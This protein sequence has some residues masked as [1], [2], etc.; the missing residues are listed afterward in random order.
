MLGKDQTLIITCFLLSA[1]ITYKHQQAG[2][3]F[4]QSTKMCTQLF[5]SEVVNVF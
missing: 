3:K 4:D 5:Y 2:W 1:P